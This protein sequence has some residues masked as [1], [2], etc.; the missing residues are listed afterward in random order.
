MIAS[1]LAPYRRIFTPATALFS[2]T[3]LV[4]RLPISMVG[5][6]IVLLAEHETGSYAFAGAV[7]ATALIA[8]AAFAV[9]QGRLLDRHGQ[10]RVLPLLITLWGVGLAAG[11]LSLTADWPVWTT[12]ALAAVAGAS[13]PSVGTCVRARW[14]HCLKDE[15]DALHTAFSFEAVADEAVFLLGPIVVTMLATAVHPVA[16]LSAALAF[17]LVG[18]Y[19]FAGL[20][21]TEPPVHP[22]PAAGAQRSAMPWLAVGALTVLTFALGVLF[23]AA[24]VSTVAFS[25]EQ[26]QQGAAGFLLAIWALGSLIAG[27]VSGAI[28]WRQGALVRLRWGALGMA[29]AMVPLALVPSI[30]L[31]ALVLLIGGFAISPTLIAAM[32]LAQQVLPEARLTEG[33]MLL[34]TGIALGLA[35]GAALAGVVIEESG[36]SAA[37]LVSLGGG[38]LALAAALATRVPEHVRTDA[39]PAER[40]LEG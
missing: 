20:R 6:G 10:A 25:E 40:V 16:G 36:A 9:P 14:S 30:P 1:A 22:L 13:L 38:V 2:L 15:P 17:G 34:Q 33:M 26:G 23:G 27:L 4:A 12:Y 39:A 28:S 18:T 7:S 35:P 29:A 8:N 19:V 31:M 32:S 24:E 21:S 37:Y 3:G 11:M 5:L